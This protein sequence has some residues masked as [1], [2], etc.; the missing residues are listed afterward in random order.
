MNILLYNGS[1]LHCAPRII[2]K[3]SNR[4]IGQTMFIVGNGSS[5]RQEILFAIN[6]LEVSNGKQHYEYIV[7]TV[8][9]KTRFKQNF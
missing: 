4:T 7:Q 2:R 8:G 6:E 1:G 3:L 9:M 5:Y